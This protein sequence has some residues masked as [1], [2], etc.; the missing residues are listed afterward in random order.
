MN[1]VKSTN[2]G[3][4]IYRGKLKC[5]SGNHEDKI[6]GSLDAISVGEKFITALDEEVTCF[7]IDIDEYTK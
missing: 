7:L 3:I 6:Y 4:I 1:Q 2:L 5:K